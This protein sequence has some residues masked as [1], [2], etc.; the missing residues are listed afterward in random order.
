MIVPPTFICLKKKR[1]P[2]F[3]F[4]LFCFLSK[5]VILFWK[6]SLVVP[7]P[8]CCCAG[9][10]WRNFSARYC[11]FWGPLDLVAWSVA[12]NVVAV[13]DLHRSWQH[14]IL[15]NTFKLRNFN[16]N[17]T[18]PQS[19]VYFPNAINFQRGMFFYSCLIKNFCGLHS[20]ILEMFSAGYKSL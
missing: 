14:K 1:S 11:G 13:G 20:N 3:V 6:A 4:V 19:S 2:L 17:D 10:S 16:T 8:C 7:S 5:G 18:V 9:L 15:N 12:V